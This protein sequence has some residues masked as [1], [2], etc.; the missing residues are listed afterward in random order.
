MRL[1]EPGVYQV[2]G[3]D[4]E[5][6]A[7]VVGETPH[8]RI[9][10]AIIMNDAFQKAKFREVKEESLEIQSIYA[11]PEMYV[12]Y[13]YESS[14]VCQLPI[15]LRS[16]RGAKM[17]SIDDAMYH[18][19]KERYKVDTS[20]PGRGAMSTKVYIMSMTGWSAAQA[21]LVI[22]KIAREI[23]KEN[24]I[25]GRYRNDCH[26]QQPLEVRP[27]MGHRSGRRF[28]QLS[29]LQ[30]PLPTRRIE[31]ARRLRANGGKQHYGQQHIPSARLV[32]KLS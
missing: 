8:L 5:L 11:H 32:C 3:S 29:H 17:P 9:V 25:P 19:F 24:G 28:F 13:P 26:P 14:D 2:V 23:K 6:L 30:Q 18:T 20:I 31:I 15:E 10:S 22:C 16:M 21:Q 1:N 7:I 12:F 27:W 4:I